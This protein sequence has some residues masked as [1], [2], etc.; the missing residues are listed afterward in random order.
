MALLASRNGSH[1]PPGMPDYDDICEDYP[2]YNTYDEM[3]DNMSTCSGSVNDILDHL[4]DED[5]RDSADL[6]AIDFDDMTIPDVINVNGNHKY[7]SGSH[8]KLSNSVGLNSSA[9]NK[10][11]RDEGKNDVENNGHIMR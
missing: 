3:T 6:D 5:L 10:T 11:L 4:N 7:M 8:Y 9:N 1:P 2:D